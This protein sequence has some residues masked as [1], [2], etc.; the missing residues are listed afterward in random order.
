MRGAVSSRSLVRLAGPCICIVLAFASWVPAS[1]ADT[2]VY[3]KDTWGVGRAITV[4]QDGGSAEPLSI[5]GQAPALAPDGQRVAFVAGQPGSGL[6]WLSITDIEGHGPHEI[7]ELPEAEWGY[8]PYLTWTPNGSGLLA[9]GYEQ[10]DIA[11]LRPVQSQPEWEA[12]PVISWPGIQWGPVAVSASGTKIAFISY[13]DPTGA[14]LG[15]EAPALYMANRNG[16]SPERLSPKGLFAFQ[17]TFSPDGSKIAF[18]GYEGSGDLEIYVLTLKN[19]SVK[20]I[21]S[22]AVDDES[23]D[24]RSDGRIGY[25]REEHKGYDYGEFRTMESS[26]KNDERMAGPFNTEEGLFWGPPSYAAIPG[27]AVTLGPESETQAR[28]LLLR[29]AP[30]MLYDSQETFRAMTADSFTDFYGPNNET[31]ESNRL[32]RVGL[33]N[34]PVIAYSNPNLSN[35]NLSLSFLKPEGQMYPNSEFVGPDVISAHGENELDSVIDIAQLEE[36]GGYSNTVYGRTEYSGGQ[37]WLQYWFFYYYNPWITTTIGDHEGDW[38]M[39]QLGLNQAGIATTATYAQHSDAEVCSWSDL[40]T[41]IG[42]YGNIAPDVFVARGSHASYMDDSEDLQIFDS[43]D[44]AYPVPV[45]VAPLEDTTAWALWPGIWGDS[46]SS[47]SSPAGQGDKWNDPAAFY[48]NAD[49][50]R[51]ESPSLA[52]KRAQGP[53]RPSLSAHRRADEIVVSYRAQASETSVSAVVITAAREDSEFAPTGATF[54]TMDGVGTARIPMPPGRGRITVSGRVIT[55]N[56]G[57]SEPATIPMR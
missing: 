47:P 37:W 34:P 11:E 27:E 21:T 28:Q 56:E 50:C 13:T 7:K 25:M 3:E 44:A 32:R 5:V 18:S 36:Q 40:H 33:S 55:T 15:A 26:G 30:K 10:G 1:S 2:F 4:Q 14:S 20:A 39:I 42:Y 8:M 49:F 57:Q 54:K 31:S 45:K 12:T 29:Y 51:I 6:N 24:W 16:S 9:S 46:E 22:N 19:G 43:T 53:G 17:P 35:P 23:P 38:E 52:A 41:S 48:E